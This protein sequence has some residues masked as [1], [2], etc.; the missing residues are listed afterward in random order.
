MKNIRIHFDS[1]MRWKAY[2]IV[3]ICIMVG[4]VYGNV[5]VNQDKPLTVFAASNSSSVKKNIKK[6]KGK[7]LVEKATWNDKGGVWKN[8]KITIK[9]K[10]STLKQKK[11]IYKKISK[12]VRKQFR[13]MTYQIQISNSPSFNTK[14]KETLY[15]KGQKGLNLDGTV[16][17]VNKK[18]FTVKAGE[19]LTH[20]EIVRYKQGEEIKLYV[21]VRPYISKSKA[22]K[23]SKVVTVSLKEEDKKEY[24]PDDAIGTYVTVFSCGDM[25]LKADGT[26]IYNIDLRT[27]YGMDWFKDVTVLVENVTPPKWKGVY[28][29]NICKQLQI[30]PNSIDISDYK[31]ESVAKG[32]TEA[33]PAY[34]QMTLNIKVSMDVMCIKITILK[35]GV[36]IPLRDYGVTTKQE[37]II[38][39][40]CLDDSPKLV[41]LCRLVRK[42]IEDELWTEDMSK[43]DKLY[44]IGSYLETINYYVPEYYP[45]I[46]DW[47]YKGTRSPIADGIGGNIMCTQGA[48]GTCWMVSDLVYYA[49]DL[50]IPLVSYEEGIEGRIEGEYVEGVEQ[51]ECVYFGYKE[52][53]SNPSAAMHMTLYY[54]TDEIDECWRLAENNE[55]ES[56]IGYVRCTY[57]IQGKDAGS[58][59]TRT[60]IV[61]K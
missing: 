2:L 39:W 53:S 12:K 36:E 22:G 47:E 18:R 48:W 27:D 24:I 56:Y 16:R 58:E 50:G 8:E 21:R 29:E 14:Y 3:L 1:Y 61:L 45:D 11:L 40:S 33:Y 49:E 6:L 28:T 42:Q 20:D 15:S 44:A 31:F 38:W 46:N 43:S 35:D 30:I 59:L 32:P 7:A 10:Y 57:D 41:E 52:T 34:N 5:I 54:N 51:K 19:V 13:K 4:F 37:H 60:P 17:G 55:W 26:T 25:E 23:W 9:L